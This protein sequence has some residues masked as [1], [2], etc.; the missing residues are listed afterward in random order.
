[1]QKLLSG[2]A[3]VLLLCTSCHAADN[4][5]LITIDGLRW[6]DVFEGYDQ[7]I[8]QEKS[9][10]RHPENIEKKYGGDNATDRR[11]KLMPFLW[12][13]IAKQGALLGN[14][15]KGSRMEVTNPWWFS[16]PGYNEILTGKAD[17]A[18]DSN[19]SVPNRN[20]TFLEWLNGKAAYRGKVASFGSWDAFPAIINRGRS[21]VYVNAGFEPANWPGLSGRAQLLNELLGETPTPWDNVRFD[22]YTY[23]LARDYLQQ[24]KPRVLYIAL[25]ETDDFAH[26]KKYG[27][28][29]DA[30]HR[31]DRFIGN[32]WRTLQSMDGYRNNTNLIITV[33]HGRGR[34]AAT[35]PH[36][37]SPKAIQKNRPDQKQ[38]LETGI[39]GSN[40][41]WLA[42]LGPDIKARGEYSG[43]D[44]VYQNQVAATALLLLNEQPGNY[45]ADIGSPLRVLLK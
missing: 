3:M 24:N 7:S 11:G 17:P 14:R 6:Q 41:I 16:Y 30:A 21:G 4:L 22:A 1:M 5:V 38:L 43:G 34:D 12:Q 19:D 28:Y 32:L 10:T 25:G 29:L 23:D 44:T 26:D 8:V 18:I 27:Q 35:W 42:A 40:E 33:D 15:D 36:H 39:P 13:T 31:A 37:A 9:L 20:T 45:A 2:L